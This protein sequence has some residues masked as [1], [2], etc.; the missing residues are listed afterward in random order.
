MIIVEVVSSLRSVCVLIFVVRMPNF[1]L[2]L[3]LRSFMFFIR[4][5]SIISR[6]VS[7]TLLIA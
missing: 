1:L 7:V 4:C 6:L 5:L 2:S 3:S